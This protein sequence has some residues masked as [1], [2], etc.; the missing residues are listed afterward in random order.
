MV[1]CSNEKG[2]M[3]WVGELVWKDEQCEQ[4]IKDFQCTDAKQAVKI[5]TSCH[6][7]KLK[8]T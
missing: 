5:C 7:Y 3:L 4:C 8:K 2:K 1:T 6:A